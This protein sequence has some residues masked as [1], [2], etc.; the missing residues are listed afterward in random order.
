[1]IL[2][3]I[4]RIRSSLQFGGAIRA[5]RLKK[6]VTGSDEW[7][8]T[9]SLAIRATSSIRDSGINRWRRPSLTLRWASVMRIAEF[10]GPYES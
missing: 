7:I 8:A 10:M 4:R 6:T 5:A 1:M 9:K 3:R 2:S